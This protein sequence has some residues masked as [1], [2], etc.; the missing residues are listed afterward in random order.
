MAFPAAHATVIFMKALGPLNNRIVAALFPIL[1]GLTAVPVSGAGL[2]D[3]FAKLQAA[4]P[5][6]AARLERQ[7]WREWSKSGSAAMDLLLQRGRDALDNG[8]TTLAIE[9]YT[10]LIDH[11]PDFAE[12]WNGRATAYFQAGLYGPSVADIQHVLALNPR[13]FG[14]I[15]GFARI[16]EETEQPERAL[17]LYRAALAI[18]PNLDG[19]REAIDRL[20]AKS[21]G[22]EI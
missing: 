14:A 20:E 18:H 21:A 2:D 19:V 22:Q 12:G 17:V 4:E 1:V 6:E 8:E 15:T 7:I 13:H 3:L 11:A 16:L 9:H 10:A 5:A